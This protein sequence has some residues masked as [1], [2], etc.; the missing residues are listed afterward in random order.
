M[1]ERFPQIPLVEIVKMW[2]EQWNMPFYSEDSKILVE[3][4]NTNFT[5]TSNSEMVN[6]IFKVHEKFPENP[7]ME[8]FKI[9]TAEE[10]KP[11]TCKHIY[12]YI[13]ILKAGELIHSVQSK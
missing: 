4:F 3:F 5:N 6:F 8:L 9:W 13:Y 12:I 7:L 2:L 1:R 10:Y 11:K